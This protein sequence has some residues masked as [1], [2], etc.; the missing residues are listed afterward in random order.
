MSTYDGSY[1]YI[2]S[3]IYE[4]HCYASASPLNQA[5]VLSSAAKLVGQVTARKFEWR[6]PNNAVA[7]I[8]ALNTPRAFIFA[9]APPR[10]TVTHQQRRTKVRDWD[11]TFN[12][13][14]DDHF[15]LKDLQEFESADFAYLSRLSTVERKSA[16]VSLPERRTYS[17][18]LHNLLTKPH[19]YLSPVNFKINKSGLKP[20]SKSKPIILCLQALAPTS[21]SRH[22]WIVPI[23]GRLPWAAC[24][25][26]VI[27]GDGVNSISDI[28]SLPSTSEEEIIW[29][30]GSVQQFWK[31][32]VYFRQ[33]GRLGPIGL[34]FQVAPEAP[35]G[36]SSLKSPDETPKTDILSVD[37]V[38]I[39]HDGELSMFVRNILQLWAYRSH[40]DEPGVRVLRGARLVLTDHRGKA[41][42]VS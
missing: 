36:S 2:A 14:L 12:P 29:T 11:E 35:S 20:Y 26:A 34:S 15:E 25:S 38:K 30:P 31:F 18:P 39:H 27:L 21:L 8:C 33:K 24:S 5:D 22:T 10:L 23:R 16:V 6:T 17:A 37:L 40:E 41:L 9:Q 1:H 28:P 7:S 4:A 3:P 13:E 32:L 42:L 19:V